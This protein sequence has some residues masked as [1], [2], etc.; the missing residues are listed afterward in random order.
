MIPTPHSPSFTTWPDVMAPGT[1]TRSFR[2]WLLLVNGHSA[3]TASSYASLCRRVERDLALSLD[4][5][6][7]TA[8]GL[9]GVIER[10]RDEMLPNASAKSRREGQAS[11]V[12][13]TRRYAEFLSGRVATAP[14]APSPAA[15]PSPRLVDVPPSSA[16]VHSIHSSYREMLLEHLFAG[17]IMRL[18]WLKGYRRMEL[19]KPQVD[20]GGYDLVLEANRI[21]RH[22]QLKASHHGAATARVNVNIA[23]AE[24][25]SGCVVWI[26][27][28]PHNLDLGPFFW[29]GGAPGDTL[30]DLASFPVAKHT[31]GN[32]TGVKTERPNIRRIP[33]ARFDEL[34]TIDEVVARLFGVEPRSRS[35]T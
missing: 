28:D 9:A 35:R 8:A 15:A 12:S 32:A 17:S 23:L 10:I 16:T 4:A 25:P 2:S 3:G 5:S 31:K 21:V 1:S 22:V 33:V 18:L 29:F 19:L 26:R 6:V 27:F 30:P 24:K 11:L 20:D 7:A 14:G 34:G 13:A